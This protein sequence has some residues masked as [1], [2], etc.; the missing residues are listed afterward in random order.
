M[1]GTVVNI[2]LNT[3]SNLYGAKVK[4]AILTKEG[5][6]PN[7]MIT[8]LEEIEDAKIL[9]LMSAFAR[10][11]GITTEELW[12]KLG[13]NNIASFYKWFPSYFDKSSA[14]GFMFLPTLG[15]LAV[16]L[17]GFFDPIA[18][19]TFIKSNDSWA[20][21][22]RLV[23]LITEIVIVAIMYGIYKSDEKTKGLL[24]SQDGLTS[25]TV[26]YNN[27]VY[28]SFDDAS[29][30]DTYTLYYSD[31]KNVVVLKRTPYVNS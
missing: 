13:Q 11:E 22:I 30:E 5:W 3:I 2:W 6:N 21:F 19:W 1:K 20:I 24:E 9:A 16:L 31:N 26:A 29:S 17:V 15:I 12:R 7:K 4:D 23:I 10:N 8:P 28:Y 25:K 18:M 27:Y 14:M